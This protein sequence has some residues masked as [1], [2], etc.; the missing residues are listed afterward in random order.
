MGTNGGK[1]PGAGRKRKVD[2]EWARN[3]CIDAV[4]N[5]FGSVEEGIAIILAGKEERLKL[6]VWTHILGNVETTSKVKLAGHKGEKLDNPMGG[7]KLIIEV[8]RTV[9]NK[10]TQDDGSTPNENDDSTR[11]PEQEF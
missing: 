8:V 4:I 7:G 6:F 1:R 11:L 5:K 3:I 9:H 10:D 2:E